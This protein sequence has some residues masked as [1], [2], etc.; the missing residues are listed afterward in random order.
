LVK[1]ILKIFPQSAPTVGHLAAGQAQ[2]KFKEGLSTFN[3]CTTWFKWLDQAPQLCL[4]QNQVH[5]I[6]KRAFVC[7]LADKIR[8]GGGKTDLFQFVSI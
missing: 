7:A 6:E 4:V 8:S 5:L 2:T 3:A 1:F